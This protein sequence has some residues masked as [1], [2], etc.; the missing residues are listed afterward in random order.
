VVSAQ[1]GGTE[2]QFMTIDA[3]EAAIR[4]VI[5]A[6]IAR[7]DEANGR[8]LDALL[9][10]RQAETIVKDLEHAGYEIRRRS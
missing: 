4:T 6:A 8:G 9:A 5:A 10:M 1:S 2:S 7:H 3:D